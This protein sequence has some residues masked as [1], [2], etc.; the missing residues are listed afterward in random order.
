MI[1][2]KQIASALNDMILHM[3]AELDRSLLM[4]KASC[5]DSEFVAY[6]EFV[7]QIL[8]TMLVDFM[9]PLYARHPDLKPP[10]LA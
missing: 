6:R 2:D 8:T 10:D 1:S 5:P 9:N 7:S 3:G 4:V